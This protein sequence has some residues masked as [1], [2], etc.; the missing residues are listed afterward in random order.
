MPALAGSG[1]ALS[2]QAKRKST[3][4]PHSAHK[5]RFRMSYFLLSLF[6]QINLRLTYIITKWRCDPYSKLSICVAAQNGIRAI[7]QDL[8][9]MLD[10]G[11]CK[12]NSTIN[13]YK[14]QVD[15]QR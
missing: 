8:K 7:V 1:V 3:P 6:C 2:P 10:R 13:F 11:A 4:R 15:I 12:L 5:H 14:G 9:R